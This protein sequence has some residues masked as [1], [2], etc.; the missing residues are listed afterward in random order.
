[1]R[2]GV[3]KDNKL[4]LRDLRASQTSDGLTK[5]KKEMKKKEEW[6]KKTANIYIG[7]HIPENVRIQEEG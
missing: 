3:M 1:M 6:E 2:V 4:K 5:K 7:K